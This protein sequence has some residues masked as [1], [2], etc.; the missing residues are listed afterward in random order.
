MEI[1]SIWS[2]V[3]NLKETGRIKFWGK[4]PQDP[5]DYEGCLSS[6]LGERL[7]ATQVLEPVPKCHI[8]RL[9]RQYA[10]R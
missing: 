1:A 10:V 8:L 3:P 5:G 9:G 4:V 2:D 7:K 6:C